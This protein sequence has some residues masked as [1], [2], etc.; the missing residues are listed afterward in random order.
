DGKI[1]YTSNTHNV[2]QLLLVNADGSGQKKI[3]TDAKAVPGL[4]VSPDGRYIVFVT[5]RAGAS[6]IW[7]M[8]IDGGNP[9]QLT[10]GTRDQTPSISPDGRWV[11]YTA[12]ESEKPRI[13]K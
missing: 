13:R 4:S 5:T 12:N 7:R 1:V 8:D 2:R 3:M 11:F 6:N 10:T 9:R